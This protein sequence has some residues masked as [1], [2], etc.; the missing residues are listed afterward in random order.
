MNRLPSK[1]ADDLDTIETLKRH[2]SAQSETSTSQGTLLSYMSTTHAAANPG[3][4]DFCSFLSLITE[5]FC[6]PGAVTLP[7]QSKIVNLMAISNDIYDLVF[8]FLREHWKFKVK[9]VTPTSTKKGEI[10]MGN[11]VKSYTH[12]LV[13]QVRYGAGSTTRGL[14]YRF[15][16]IDGRIPVQIANIYS[17]THTRDDKDDA[18]LTASIAIVQRFNRSP[19][20]P[21]MP[22]DLWYVDRYC[23]CCLMRLTCS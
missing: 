3:I 10:F 11:D 16:Y 13:D 12:V 23:V 17:V 2:L 22:W 18:P 1:D 6:L 8:E 9:L 4:V 7:R 19:Q 20:M 21:E 5:I 14:G 15:G